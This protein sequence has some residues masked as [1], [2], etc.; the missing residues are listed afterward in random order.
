MG[1]YNNKFIREFKRSEFN[2]NI[3]C[4]LLCY[5]I[6]GFNKRQTDKEKCT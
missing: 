3:T 4:F 2:I 1:S 6:F 5:P